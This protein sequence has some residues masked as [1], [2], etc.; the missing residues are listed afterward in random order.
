MRRKAYLLLMVV[1]L[2]LVLAV[3]FAVEIGGLQAYHLGMS[4]EEA[5]ALMHNQFPSISVGLDYDNAPTLEQMERDPRLYIYDEDHGIILFFNHHDKLIDKRKIKW[6]GINVVKVREY[7]R[8]K[9]VSCLGLFY[10]TEGAGLGRER[11]STIA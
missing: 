6:F 3:Q 11:G 2:L 5:R 9:G 1:G 7:L 10:G 8:R 4:I